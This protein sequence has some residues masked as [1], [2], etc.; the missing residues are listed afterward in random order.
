[1]PSFR[2]HQADAFSSLLA[3]ARRPACSERLLGIPR[4][5]PDEIACSWV[6]FSSPGPPFLVALPSCRAPTRS[7]TSPR[8]GTI[9]RAL[10][11]A[12]DVAA[13]LRRHLFS[14]SSRLP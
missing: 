12:A 4:L 9:H 5:S 3:T 1:M 11:P 14:L 6:V 7:A 8:R 13:T 10:F 2:T